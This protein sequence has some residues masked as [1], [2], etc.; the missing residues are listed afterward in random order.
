MSQDK[1]IWGNYTWKF[2]HT[3]AEKVDSEKFLNIK[4]DLINIVLETCNYLPC[5]DCSEHAVRVLKQAYLQ[6]IES[7]DDFKQFLRQFH[8][9]VNIKL[10]KECVSKEKLD[11]MYKDE[12]LNLLLNKL[13]N[14]YLIIRTSDRMMSYN[15][16]KK[17]YLR[18]LVNNLNRLKDNFN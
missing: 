14:S 8:N 7:K 18:K 4:D 15:F 17:I 13:V 2:F 11:N 16:Q 1:L 3:L 5:P 12:N 10:E 6:K 9:I